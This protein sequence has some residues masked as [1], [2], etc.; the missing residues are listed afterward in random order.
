MKKKETA[1][2]IPDSLK[3]LSKPVPSDSSLLPA[4]IQDTGFFE[5][6][7]EADDT[8]SLRKSPSALTTK[9]RYTAKDSIVYDAATR[10][11]YLYG[12]AQVF[13]ED[14]NLTAD[15]IHIE[16]DK[17]LIH[18]EGRPDSTGA[19]AGTP[20]FKQGEQEY[21]AQQIA[22]NYKSR[23]G[24]LSEFKTKE[25]EGYVHGTNVKRSPDNEFGIRDAY[26]TTCDLDTPHFEIRARRLKII[27]DKKVITGSA[28]LWIEHLPTPLFLPFGIFSIKRGQ[29]SG[30]IIPTYGS[31]INR[32]FFL[33]N[34]GYYLG[35]G[36][37]ADLALTGD[38]Y[39]QGSWAGNAFFRY[40]NRYRFGGQLGFSYANNKFGNQEDPGF[41][42][43]KDFR[44]T[45]I[46]TVDPKA[47]PGT[48]FSANVN[49]VSNSYLANNSYV[50]QNVVS[51]QI[52]S[53][54]AYSK[55]FAQGKYNLTSN[56]RVSQNLQT[57]D[58]GITLPDLTFTVSSFNPFKPKS[59][60]SAEY[61]Y[62]N[63]STNYSVVF[64]NE[65]NTKDSLLFRNW[66]GNEFRNFYDTTGKYG[67]LHSLPVQTSF[68]LF[69]FYTLSASVQLNEY[70]YMQS[71]NKEMVGNTLV[72]KTESGFVRAFSFL[73]RV[74]LNTRYYGMKNFNGKTLKAIRHVV[75]PTVDFSYKPDYSTNFWGYY[76]SYTDTLGVQRQYSMFERG[77]F[78]GPSA[79]REGNIGFSVD[80]NL[81]IKV[82]RGKDTARKE[83]KIQIF[84]T[85]RI[86]SAYNMFADSLNLRPFSLTARTKLFKNITVNS[87]ANLD[88]Y[89]NEFTTVNNF[90]RVTRVN[91]F[92]WKDS[93]SLGIITDANLGVSASFTPA[94]F[95]RSVPLTD[96]YMD[97]RQYIG[98]NP[99]DYYDFNIPWTLNINYTIQY[100]RFGYTD[101]RKSQYTQTL[102][103]SGDLNLTENWKIA[104]SSGYD[105]QLKQITYTSVDF[106]RNL[107]C[108]E[109]RLNWIPVGFRQ[110]FNFQ[111]NVKA[112]VLQELKLTRRRDWFDRQI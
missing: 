72:T 54:V 27:P 62:E 66:K 18:A 23:K 107:H 93:R 3:T 92:Y 29:S 30:V 50:P 40:A 106:I 87:S 13:Y 48:Y 42:Q 61:W 70:W 111:I 108:W 51:N 103:F 91:R 73:P 36:D 19:L 85:F 71:V 34:G 109:F 21:K 52:I 1:I 83:E 101:V 39:S 33:R 76:K 90:T 105:F 80:N 12:N 46:H 63:I 58:I 2:Q 68:K 32:G 65:I 67:I 112:S 86:G 77:I 64:R 15:Y 81:E 84:E 35:L 96:R 49:L 97:E 8:A 4:D 37:K 31:S 9:V 60:P 41:N 38:I 11:V 99:Q 56:A 28:N 75:S 69:K 57:R 14:I 43:S 20:V 100:Y 79:G 89:V 5:I 95:K 6:N 25:G 26:Y 88:P 98:N 47:R 82:M 16:L 45:W 7:D 17:T 24:F 94:T 10:I 110:S 44:L 78:G 22:Y 102:N 55:S 53:S 104:M 59:K 74:G